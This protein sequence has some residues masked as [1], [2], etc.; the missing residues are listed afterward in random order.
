MKT[1]EDINK[2]CELS[3][4]DMICR[5]HQLY[6]AFRALPGY[7]KTWIDTY[8]TVIVYGGELTDEQRL[9]YEQLKESVFT[10]IDCARKAEQAFKED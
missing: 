1:T 2:E 6:R 7:I 3:I 10:I 4:Q 8:N 9:R 5:K